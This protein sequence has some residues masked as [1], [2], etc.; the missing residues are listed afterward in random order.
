[1]NAQF[2]HYVT[3][4][5]FQLTLSQRQIDM[6]FQMAESNEPI[7]SGP[8]MLTERALTRRGFAIREPIE[9]HGTQLV[10]TRA[11]GLMVHLLREA[12]FFSP[13]WQKCPSPE[14][15]AALIA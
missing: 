9:P 4:A 2:Q 5:T 7:Y 8:W 12:G 6:L 1:M 10:L 13:G 3:S 11:G 15:K 14:E